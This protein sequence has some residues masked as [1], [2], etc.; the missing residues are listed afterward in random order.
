MSAVTRDVWPDTT[1]RSYT[2]LPDAGEDRKPVFDA[3][4][5][6]FYSTEQ[7]AHST[8]TRACGTRSSRPDYPIH[9]ASRRSL[10]RA[11]ACWHSGRR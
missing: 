10:S 9:E 3:N 7:A 11:P 8:F 5:N 4:D 1:A 6:D 2:Q